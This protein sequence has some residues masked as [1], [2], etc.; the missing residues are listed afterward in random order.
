[1]AKVVI[2]GALF[3]DNEANEIFKPHF[4]GEFKLVDADRYITKEDFISEYNE[5]DLAQ[6]EEEGEYVIYKGET[7]YKT[8]YCSLWSTEGDIDLISDISNLIYLEE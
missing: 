7:Y 6:A 1:M 3:Y 8:P 5:E 2:A 4:S